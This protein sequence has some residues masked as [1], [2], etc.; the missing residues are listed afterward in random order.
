MGTKGERKERV[1]AAFR[2]MKDIGIPEEKTKQVLKKLLKLYDRNWEVIE[3]ENYRLLADA[4]FDDDDDS[5]VEG[6]KMTFGNMNPRETLEEEDE[7]QEEPERPLK[8][9]HLKQQDGV[10]DPYSD[11]TSSKKAKFQHDGGPEVQ[12]ETV[13]DRIRSPSSS[14]WN[15]SSEPLSPTPLKNKGKQPLTQEAPSLNKLTAGRASGALQI[16]EPRVEHTVSSTNALIIPKNEPV[17]DDMPLAVVHPESQGGIP[18]N[19]NGSLRRLRRGS[20]SSRS[21][22]KVPNY[23]GGET[24]SAEVQRNLKG[25][26]ISRNSSTTLEVASSASG[27][28][29]LYLSCNFVPKQSNFRAP[30]LDDVIK[31]VQDKCLR[32]YKIVDPSFSLEKLMRDFCESFLEL[33]TNVSDDFQEEPLNVTPAGN[34]LITSDPVHAVGPC[35]DGGTEATSVLDGFVNGK[36]SDNIAVT[37]LP[38]LPSPLPYSENG[39]TSNEEDVDN[40]HVEE[41]L[42]TSMDKNEHS[43][44]VIGQRPLSPDDIRRLHDVDD[45]TRGEENVKVPLLLDSNIELLPS[46]HYISQNV[47]AQDANVNI[48]LAQIGEEDCC[49][50]C[51]GDCLPSTMPCACT[52]RNGGEFTYTSDGVLKDE[53]L[54]ECIAT[55]RNPQKQ[56][57]H[58]CEQCPL[59]KLR[60]EDM[61]EPCRGHLERKF[62]KECWSKCGCSK[63]CAN[64]VVQ[65]GIKYMLQVFLTPEGKGW[66]LRTLEDLPKGAFVCEFVGEILTILELHQRNLRTSNATHSYA[67]LLDADWGSREMKDEQALCL[68]ATSY[69]N[70]AR[71]INHRCLDANLVNIPV[72][73]DSTNHQYYRVAFFTARKVDALE[74]LTWDYGVD[75][76][77]PDH[78]LKAFNCLCGS[79]FCRSMKRSSRT[80][81][82][83]VPQ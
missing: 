46:F 24:T 12:N 21:A 72:E 56:K 62:I 9:M 29:K 54:E 73:V 67:L 83:S 52:C 15:G 43:L 53:C 18:P 2:A 79:S 25:S 28:A 4:I 33:G 49:P 36:S 17:T 11:E 71:F 8:R 20:E 27:E 63:H 23:V 38:S 14:V 61:S 60:G 65:R 77:D 45:V 69:G 66:G 51:C 35:D 74:E 5:Q 68:D 81:S 59:E 32:S 37:N 50:T 47:V 76:E 40:G 78:L 34:E 41:D 55:I 10:S 44:V 7:P 16:K 42:S 26:D 58:H 13:Q 70:V 57:L 80:R 31:Y 48:S 30:C 3:A 39:L 64:R 75:F 1:Y 19:G 22:N 6:R 82:A